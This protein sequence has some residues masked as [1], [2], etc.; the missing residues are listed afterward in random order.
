[1]D[2]YQGSNVIEFSFWSAKNDRIKL[3]KLYNLEAPHETVIWYLFR[4]RRF[5]G[6]LFMCKVEKYFGFGYQPVGL[7]SL[8]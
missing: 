3:H 2:E 1:M 7:G 6:C 4:L 5:L 8:V